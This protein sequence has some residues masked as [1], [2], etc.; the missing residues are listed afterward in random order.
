MLFEKFTELSYYDKCGRILLYFTAALLLALA[1]IGIITKKYNSAKL[2]DFSKYA[3]GI[4]VGYALCACVIM[5]TIKLDEMITSDEIIPKLFYPL[6]SCIATAIALVIGGLIIS[7]LKPEKIKAYTLIS[8]GIFAIPLIIAIVMISIYYSKEV[9]PSGWYSNVSDLGLGLGAAALSILIVALALVFGKKNEKTTTKSIVYA[10]VLVAFSFA[11][12]YIRLFRLPQGGS[13]T[14]ASALPIML[15]SYMFGIRKGVLV[16]VIYGI[17]QAI[18]DPWIIHPAQFLLDYPIAFSALG[19]VGILKEVKLF[20][21]KPAISF[22]LGGVIGGALRYF[23]HV[24]SGIFAFSSYAGEGY[25]AVAWGFLYN[26]F[27]LVD[28]AIVLIAGGIMLS[29]KY[30]SDFVKKASELE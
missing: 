13:V 11:L 15:Y 6:L 7:L 12:S 14:F 3:I 20:S 19:L 5:L 22:I 29:T 28:L 27:A 10:A 24:L 2:A 26:S 30:F 21:K 9:V 23:S 1:V 4:L 17:L 8:L 16:G 25:G 18:Q